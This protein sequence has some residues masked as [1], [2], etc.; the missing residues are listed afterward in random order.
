MKN[1]QAM[2]ND[3][4][5]QYV[6][7]VDLGATKIYAAVIDKKGKI[8]GST[9][10][11][12]NAEEG[13]NQV[14]DR[15][16][17]CIMKAIESCG[18][19]LAE[20]GAI[21]VGSPGPLNL[22][23]GSI[24]ETPNLGWKDAPLKS[25]L[26]KTLKKPVKVDNDGNVGILGEYAYGAGHGAQHMVGLFVGTGIGGGVIID[27]KLL[28][29]FNENAGELGHMILDPN[30]PLCGCG[31]KGCLEAF[32]SRLAI[33]KQ[34]RI[35]VINDL[36]STTIFKKTKRKYD[37]ISS[38]ILAKSYAD[39]DPAV[40]AAIDRSATYLGY[41]TASLLNIFNPEVVVI[42]GGV[43]EALGYEYVKTVARVAVENAFAIAS[44][45]VRIVPAE[46]KDDSAVLGASFLAWQ[47]IG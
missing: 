15:M 45:N 5:Y 30:G 12:T 34:I 40:V 16:F 21:G 42:G 29:G 4:N 19:T 41:A 32:S 36:S 38:S 2:N 43:V 8:L 47:A 20:I 17:D 25:R 18:L 3:Q 9:R 37:R 23:E 28:H 24:I 6:V 35:A 26:E 44:R 14:I 27:G 11:K 22:V 33:E 7:G 31:R 10:A 39:N 1:G 46:L 13:F